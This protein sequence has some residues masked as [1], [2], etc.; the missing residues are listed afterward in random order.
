MKLE[1][2]PAW[3]DAKENGRC[4]FAPER[5][6][7]D[8]VFDG[9]PLNGDII[10]YCVQDVLCMPDL[11]QVYSHMLPHLAGGARCRLAQKDQNGDEDESEGCRECIL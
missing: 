11:W 1:E 5:G 8:A 2:K 10:T 3:E 7:Q 9:R 4:I 6:G